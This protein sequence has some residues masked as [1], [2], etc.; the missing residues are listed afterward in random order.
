MTEFPHRPNLDHLRQ[1][2]KDL[3]KTGQ[4]T[5][6]L[7]A[8]LVVARDHGYASWASMKTALARFEAI[9]R[10]IELH[11]KTPA[12]D[13]PNLRASGAASVDLLSEGALKHPNPRIR[14]QCLQLLDHLANDASYG[15]FVAAL[16]DPVPRV[17]KH[18]I[19]GL[20]CDRCKENPL[21]DDVVGPL[22][23]R[24]L[25]DPSAKLRLEALKALAPRVADLRA[26][27]ALQTIARTDPDV[28]VREAAQL[29]CD[30]TDRRPRSG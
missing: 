14:W 17:R 19:H 7:E 27:K 11:G 16:Q 24:A 25:G 9:E 10:L 12:R 4:T 30:G 21:C 20:S 5:T 29:L 26:A 22:T 15:V 1:Q 6:L 3:K 13:F 18:A 28:S 8:Q 23:E 2:A